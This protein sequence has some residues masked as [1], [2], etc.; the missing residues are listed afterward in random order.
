LQDLPPI[1]DPEKLVY[2]VPYEEIANYQS[3]TACDHP[4]FPMRIGSTWEYIDD[5]ENTVT[6][7]VTDITGDLESARAFV[8]VISVV[9]GQTSR[10]TVKWICHTNGIFAAEWE[11]VPTIL[12]DDI[13]YVYTI[14]WDGALL[15]PPEYMFLGSSWC[16]NYENTYDRMVDD[17][18]LQL[19]VNY[20][21]EFTVKGIDKIQVPA[22]EFDAV[23]V[24]ASIAQQNATPSH[25]GPP[26]IYETCQEIKNVWLAKDVG[27]VRF[28]GQKVVDG[29]ASPS[30]INI[31]LVKYSIP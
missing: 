8:E 12:P 4:Y 6:W 18:Y 31:G 5:D 29:S 21:E 26:I 30:D 27:L 28:S 23:N 13:S 14:R 3:Q 25:L 9:E 17:L 10:N 2:P 11:P 15:P 22:G 20:A 16:N 1:G 7:S 24:A 19:C